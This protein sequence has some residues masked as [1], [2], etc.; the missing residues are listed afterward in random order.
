MDTSAASPVAALL[1]AAQADRAGVAFRPQY[2]PA[3]LDAAYAVQA[4]VAA[5]LRASIAGWKAGFSAAK[6]PVAAPLFADRVLASA[7]TVALPRHTPLIVEAEIGFRLAADLPP[8]PS[9]PYSRAE[10]L[11]AVAEVLVGFEL[12]A[13][14]F[15]E[16]AKVPYAAFLADNLGNAGYIAGQS[17]RAFGALDLAALRCTLAVDGATVHDKVGGH[18]QDD[19]VLPLVAYA[20]APQDRLG[21]FRA[22]QIVTTGSVALM[23]F[24]APAVVSARIEGIG[25]V[26]V[27]LSR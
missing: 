24:S 6:V 25:E 16:P 12:I 2:E 23:R 14:R 7:A 20:N 17:L 1:A 13:S 19:P 15:G 27:T 21:G 11:A 4:E 9:Q 22:G 18:P 3:D 8:R 26:S 10:V 5:A